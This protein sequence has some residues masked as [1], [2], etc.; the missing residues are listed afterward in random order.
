MKTKT[1]IKNGVTAINHSA[2]QLKVR[3]AGALQ[4]APGAVSV[5]SAPEAPGSRR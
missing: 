2:K 4:H 1:Q 5:S 3:Q